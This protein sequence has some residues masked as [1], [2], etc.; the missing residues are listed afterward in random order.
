MSH[1]PPATERSGKMQSSVVLQLI[2]F[3]LLSPAWAEGGDASDYR[4]QLGEVESMAPVDEWRAW[5]RF[6]EKY[7]ESPYG[8][9]I[10]LRMTEIEKQLPGGIPPRS[11]SSKAAPIQ[12]PMEKEAYVAPVGRSPHS[13]SKQWALVAHVGNPQ[14]FGRVTRLRLEHNQAGFEANQ[15][16]WPPELSD[17]HTLTTILGFSRDVTATLS[18]GLG[19][20]N[21]RIGDNKN[22]I[23]LDIESSIFP[24]LRSFEVS[25]AIAAKHT[26]GSDSNS[27]SGFI[28][29][30][31][32][33]LAV[34]NPVRAAYL[35]P[36][37]RFG[38]GFGF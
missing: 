27:W 31:R 34:L 13:E 19:F 2:L 15:L 6:L 30:G 28:V 1:N 23:A 36:T 12:N 37:L 32:F 29:D 3:F 38:V 21:Y 22:G 9:R 20:R 24:F 11:T 35:Y 16:E 4:A 5:D 18:L 33:G 10:R 14:F 8:D 25:P 17:K 7:P 26:F